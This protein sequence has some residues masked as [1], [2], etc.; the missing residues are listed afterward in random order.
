MFVSKLVPLSIF[1]ILIPS[2]LGWGRIGHRI[3]GEI[4]Q[5]HLPV[6]IQKSAI[7]LLDGQSFAQA[8]TWSDEIRGD[9]AYESTFW[10]HFI[11]IEDDQTL[12]TANRRKEGDIV[13]AIEKF[14]KELSNPELSR[15]QRQE[16]LKWLIHL[17]GDIHQPLHVGRSADEGGNKHQV[18]W[19]H[20]P[21]NIHKVW[22]EHII[23]N[24]KL[25]YKEYV[26]YLM[27]ALPPQ[28]VFKWQQD[29]LKTWVKES[30]ELRETVYKTGNKRLEYAYLGHNTP[31][32]NRRM[33][34]AGVRLANSIETA[35]ENVYR[36][37]KKDFTKAN[38]PWE[39]HE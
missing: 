10:Y 39:V 12:E 23:E 9:K 31:I 15:E 28:Q 16:A 37:Q 3:V 38:G 32:V 17:I 30:F 8:S 5:I 22:D 14:E 11:N 33:V 6:H 2:I 26:D 29:G 35:F 7:E 27:N 13:M 1:L 24:Q 36:S 4:A 20:I 34:Q 19:F 25:A 21:S 18:F